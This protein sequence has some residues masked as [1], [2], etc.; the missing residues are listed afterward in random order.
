MG[1]PGRDGSA[2]LGK[3]LED[4]GGIPLTLFAFNV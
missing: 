2:S 4:K 3:Q 1:Q